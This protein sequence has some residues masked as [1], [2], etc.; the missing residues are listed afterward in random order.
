M[1]WV[2]VDKYHIK[3]G[4]WMIARY[5]V[6]DAVKYTLWSGSKILGVFDSSE[7]AKREAEKGMA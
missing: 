7:E 4:E 2:S 5:R 1:Q 3:S 6:G